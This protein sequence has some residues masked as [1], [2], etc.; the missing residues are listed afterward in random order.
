MTFQFFCSC[1]YNKTFQCKTNECTFVSSQPE[2]HSNAKQMSAH[3][4]R[5]NQ[6]HI[7]QVQYM[8]LKNCLMK[9]IADIFQIYLKI[10]CT[11]K[12][13]FDKHFHMTSNTG[14]GNDLCVYAY[15]LVFK[16]FQLLLVLCYL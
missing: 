10:Y 3:L 12:E 15:L 2:A 14:N 16:L 11:K 6:K 13:K 5:H 9:Y 8:K 7:S 4:C 1:F